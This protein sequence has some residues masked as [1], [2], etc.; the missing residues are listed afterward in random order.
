MCVSLAPAILSKTTLVVGE[1]KRRGRSVHVLGYQNTAQS[2][3]PIPQVLRAGGPGPGLDHFAALIQAGKAG[4]KPKPKSATG[5]AMILPF[6]ALERMG[7]ANLIDTSRSK[8]VLKDIA[9]TVRP[10]SRSRAPVAMGMRN[11]KDA[12]QVF[13]HGIYTCVFG[14]DPD[15]LFAALDLVPEA[16]RPP[17][18]LEM[19]EAYA[20]W[21]PGWPLGIECFVVDDQYLARQG[22][23]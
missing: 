4:G 19:L 17:L 2:L 10:M 13:D 14:Y 15:S 7:P 12:V 8:R 1:A 16:K 20:R 11:S 9:E 3:A 21:Y 5:N 18:E 6:P 22:I 23:F